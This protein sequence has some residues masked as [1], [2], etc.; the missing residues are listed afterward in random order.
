LAYRQ[1]GRGDQ[2]AEPH[3]VAI[4]HEHMARAVRWSGDREERETPTEEGMS[5]VRHLDLF[6]KGLRRVVE[7]GIMKWSRLTAFLTLS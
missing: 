5:W 1:T 7:R 3:R 4:G 2:D 6:G